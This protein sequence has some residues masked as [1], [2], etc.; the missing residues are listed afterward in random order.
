MGTCGTCKHWNNNEQ[1]FSSYYIRDGMGVCQNINHLSALDKDE[2]VLV[3]C[4][5][6]EDFDAYVVTA[7]S[8]GCN[9]H[10]PKAEQV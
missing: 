4:R 8:F 5:D 3:Y 6:V 9:Q 2:S 10:E 1:L 7:P